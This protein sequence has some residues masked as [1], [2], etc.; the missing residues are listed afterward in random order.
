MHVAA[1]AELPRQPQN[2]WAHRASGPWIGCRGI[3]P[4]WAVGR[5]HLADGTFW[6]ATDRMSPVRPSGPGDRLKHNVPDLQQFQWSVKIARKRGNVVTHPYCSY[7]M[8]GGRRT[9]SECVLLNRCSLM[10]LPL[11]WE[12][13]PGVHVPQPTLRQK[14]ECRDRRA[15]CATELMRE[16][17]D[18]HEVATPPWSRKSCPTELQREPTDDASEASMIP[19]YIQL[20]PVFRTLKGSPMRIS[21]DKKIQKTG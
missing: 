9:G 4:D 16:S 11:D 12:M 3:Y 5:G 8:T 14:F 10:R 15:N 2:F 17:R 18:V 6:L 7:S 21:K 13:Y 20:T 1:P 19:I